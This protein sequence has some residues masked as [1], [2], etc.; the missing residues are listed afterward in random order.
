[1][2]SR[3]SM[4][5]VKSYIDSIPN[6]EWRKN[7]K[8]QADE[9]ELEYSN[10]EK[11]FKKNICSYCN[12]DF[13]FFDYE[14]PCCHWLLCPDKM[15]VKKYLLR[16]FITEKCKI[17][18]GFFQIQ[19]YLRWI[20]KQDSFVLNI[21]D[22]QD[23]IAEKKMVELTIKYKNIE[24]SFS[25]DP[26]DYNGHEGTHKGYY[27]HYHLQIK[28]D[29]F[30]ILGFNDF[31]IPLSDG[32]LFFFQVKKECP[33]VQF[34]NFLGESAEEILKN[35]EGCEEE[36]VDSLR[37]ASDESKDEIHLSTFLWAEEGKTI[38]GDDLLNIIKE[39]QKTKIPIA[40]LSKKLKN[41]TQK[42][43]VRPGDSIIEIQ[44]RSPKNR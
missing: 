2:K 28:K 29:G 30:V 15:R 26:S 8:I 39:S 24:W 12:K 13:S 34:G 33:E 25:I 16:L 6:D 7:N 36:F 21:N 27:P 38:S 1:M 22:F 18:G 9:M 32:D 19:L 37:N 20:A 23:E 5:S 17:V 44:K 41:V 4:S 42:T 11:L 10:F 31:H 3:L 35:M 14:K 40:V 43:F